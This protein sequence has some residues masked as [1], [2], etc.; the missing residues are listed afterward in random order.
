MVFDNDKT[1]FID[2]YTNINT[3][4]YN[5]YYKKGYTRNNMHREACGF[6]G[7]PTIVNDDDNTSSRTS[8]GE[9]GT[10]NI[11]S[12]GLKRTFR[13]ALACTI[14]YSAAVAGPTPTKA[15]VLAAMVTSVNRINGVYEKELSIHMNLVARNDT[16]IFI[17]SDS[18]SNANG[19]AMLGQNQ[20]VVDNRI[21]NANYDIGHVFSTGGGGVAQLGVICVTG[22]KAQGVTGLDN[23]VG[24]SYDIDYVAHE[25]G[26]QYGGNHTFNAGTGSCLGNRESTVAY[27]V[28]SGTTIMAYAGICDNNNPQPH[29]D[30]YFHRASLNEIYSYISSTN[31]AVTSNAGNAPPTVTSY[32]ST[33]NIP[34]KTNFEITAQAS[35]PNGRPINYC[36]EEWDLGP[37][38]NWNVTNNTRA[39]IFRSFLP[40]ASSTRTFPKY[41]SLIR[42][43]IKY[44]GEILPEVARDTKFRCTVRNINTDGY[45]AYN[46]PDVNLTVK[47]V[48]T[49]VL[50]RVTSFPTSTTFSGNSQQTINW[51]VASTTDAPIST[52]N[53]DIYLSLDSARTFPILLAGNTANDGTETVTIPDVFT[54][55]PSARIKVKGNGNIFF[56]LNDGWI[57][58]NRGVVP[59]VV[60]F[61]PGD[62]VICQKSSLTFTN[63]STGSPDSVRWTINGGTTTTSTSLTTVTSNFNNSG[64]YTVSLIAY[65]GGVA[66][67]LLT[68]TIQVKPTPTFVFTP[69]TPVV[70]AG[71]SIDITA[72]YLSGATCVWSTGSSS[73]TINVK[74]LV[75]TYYSVVVT[76]DGC[77]AKD[78]VLVNVKPVSTSTITQ[79]ICD[80]QSVTV[81]GQTFTT[82]QT[83]RIIVLANA[84]S[85]G[86]DSAIT[87]NLTVNPKSTSTITQTI[88]DGQ[89]VTV[90]GQTFTTSQTNRIILLANANS[91]GCD[92]TITLNLTVNPKSTSTITQ[93]ICDGQSVTVGGQTFTTSQTNRIIVLANANSNGCDSAITLNLTVNPKS[94]STITQTI[95]DGQSVTVGGQTFTT[96]QTNRIIVLANANSNG[97]DSTITLNLT[98][99]PK[100]TSSITQTICDGQS[101]TVGGQTFTTSQTSRIIVLANA[102]SNGC[103]STITFNLTVIAVTTPV[104]TLV[105]DSLTVANSSGTQYKWYLNSVL[106]ATTSIPKYK[107]TQ[108]GSW[109]VIVVGTNSCESL[110]SAP[111][112]VTGIKSNKSEVSFSVIP[113]PN[114]G[115]FDL[116]ITA[117]KNEKYTI[118]LYNVAG[119]E[120][121]KEELNILQGVNFKRFNLDHIEKGMYFISLTG[122]EGITTQN[123]IVQ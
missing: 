97:C 65:K 28:G 63:T 116:K 115:Q 3:G 122:K 68:K 123:I 101:V 59:V 7:A 69:L 6:A 111:F 76:N 15:R 104:I 12:T 5:C 82:S 94:T 71:D 98:V 87:L 34:Y 77:T 90:G 13:L 11:T 96:S 100:S 42:N 17:T 118:S 112:V 25:M 57:K 74:P 58:I 18:Y 35:D 4:F 48:V 24:D 120:I 75:N 26:H 51:N 60:S 45:G 62:T 99:N 73:Q 8:P 67:T 117:V 31:C 107:P 54:N 29:S 93:T 46:A 52:A 27:E 83:N 89:S 80:G 32:L 49:S 30:D 85:V 41:D 50:F 53:V 10:T 114:S 37:Q 44:L 47:S 22:L 38:G 64:F 86:C 40:T 33:Y 36:W 91:V 20:S 70:C 102:N 119:Q 113:N 81:G 88:C 105:N 43:S 23:P 95:C 9:N 39:P 14:E 108:Q 21:G 55:N 84:N 121:I 66:S 78:S 2:P 110:V 56:D 16:L 109:T 103:D 79:T 1:Y 92:S 106:Q 19:G 61:T 72:N